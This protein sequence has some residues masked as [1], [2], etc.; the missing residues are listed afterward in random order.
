M[1]ADDAIE[2]GRAMVDAARRDG[3]RP[4]AYVPPNTFITSK[5][6]GPKP[7]PVTKRSYYNQGPIECC[8]AIESAVV[9]MDPRE[10][11]YVSNAI[12]YLWRHALKHETTEG[13]VEDLRKAK[14]NI[15]RAIRLLLEEPAR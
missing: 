6:D 14:A 12:E 5:D 4:E 1:K 2:M 8:D 10:A 11:V 15:D 7:A 9:G 3:L 13:K